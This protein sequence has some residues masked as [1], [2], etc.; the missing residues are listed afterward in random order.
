M[1][2]FIILFSDE[3]YAEMRGNNAYGYYCGKIH[4]QSGLKNS[5]NYP[6][7]TDDINHEKVKVYKKYNN[8]LNTA[9]RVLK[10]CWEVKSYSIIPYLNY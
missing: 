4:Y 9:E 3:D 8:A 5:V 10:D 1:S 2:G 7:C 6:S